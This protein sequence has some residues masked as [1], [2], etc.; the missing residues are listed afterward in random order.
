MRRPSAD[1]WRSIAWI[2]AIA[3]FV[4]GVGLAIVLMRMDR[5]ASIATELRLLATHDDGKGGR[6]YLDDLATLVRRAD[7]IVVVEH[8]SPM[9]GDNDYARG[10]LERNEFVYGT[11]SLSP[12]QRRWFASTIEGLDART[13]D[14]FPACIAEVHHTLLFYLRDK[15]ISRLDVCFEC[16]QVLWQGSRADP[17]WSIYPGLA[18]VIDEVGLHPK[19]DWKKLASERV[20]AMVR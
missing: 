20:A 9:D 5:R 6:Q 17:P 8:S 15:Q 1:R 13:Q 7:R 4:S 12:S 19:R 18:L 11:R 16:G 3:L 2:A 10:L 14:V